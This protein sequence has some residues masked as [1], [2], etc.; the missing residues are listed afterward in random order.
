MNAVEAVT[1]LLSRKSVRVETQNLVR[2]GLADHLL[3]W[4]RGI[5]VPVGVT[6]FQVSEGGS[7]VVSAI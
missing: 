7:S 4:S 5:D 2:A 3:R 1:W 6:A